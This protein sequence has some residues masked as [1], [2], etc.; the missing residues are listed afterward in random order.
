[1][2]PML[3]LGIPGQKYMNK[4]FVRGLCTYMQLEASCPRSISARMHRPFLQ[5]MPS[6]ANDMNVCE[7]PH[8]VFRVC[9]AE[10]LCICAVAVSLLCLNAP[11]LFT[12][13]I[14]CKWPAI[15]LDTNAK[16]KSN[17]QIEK[18]ARREQ[19][20]PVFVKQ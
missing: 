19:C 4:P 9:T 18:K 3:C 10:L 11:N 7:V 13:I 20:H 5:H 2:A 14:V 15:L 17:G 12:A 8:L 1:M 16:L 6:T